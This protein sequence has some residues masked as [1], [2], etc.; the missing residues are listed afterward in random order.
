MEHDQDFL[1][2]A[3]IKCVNAYVPAEY[4]AAVS[5]KGRFLVQDYY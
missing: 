4:A 3:V 5:P 1:V 2:L